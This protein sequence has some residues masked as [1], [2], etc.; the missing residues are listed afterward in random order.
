MQFAETI[1]TASQ[2][3]NKGAERGAGGQ[4]PLSSEPE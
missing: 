3:A 4:I 2:Y 1:V